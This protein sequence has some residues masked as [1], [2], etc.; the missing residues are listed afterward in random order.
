MA[1]TD[2]EALPLFQDNP[3]APQAL[4]A[5]PTHLFLIDRVPQWVSRLS[6]A[7]AASSWAVGDEMVL[8]LC[9]VDDED[10]ARFLG[11]WDR[12]LQSFAF[13]GSDAAIHRALL[14]VFW[15]MGAVN[16]ESRY[17][18][19]LDGDS[20]E[21]FR[22]LTEYPVLSRSLARWWRDER[23]RCPQFPSYDPVAHLHAALCWRSN[24]EDLYDDCFPHLLSDSL[25]RPALYGNLELIQRL[26][27]S[28]RS[29]TLI[30]SAAYG[31]QQPVL[32]WVNGQMQQLPACDR[33]ALNAAKGGHMALVRW[34]YIE[35]GCPVDDPSFIQEVA[36]HQDLEM[37]RWLQ[38]T[39]GPGMFTHH[40]LHGAAQAGSNAV[41]E[42]ADEQHP[43][44]VWPSCGT[45]CESAARH[46]HLDT[47]KWLRAKGCR[48][49]MYTS[50][51]AVE[52]GHAR[53]LRYV[54]E[55]GCSTH[56]SALMTAVAKG[57]V[58]VLDVLYDHGIQMTQDVYIHSIHHGQLGVVRWLY[59]EAEVP[60]TARVCYEAAKRGELNI[61]QY[62][63]SQGCPWNKRRCW[64]A[65]GDDETREWLRQPR[66]YIGNKR[67][68]PQ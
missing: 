60:W 26:Q 59:E 56:N 29:I 30:Y 23:A 12:L 45:L 2:L 22:P 8:A 57:W 14:G 1:A 10:P 50:Q 21:H 13:V 11:D 54:L 47:V 28:P 49:D 42:W 58:G 33:V 17:R 68:K 31:G 41:L 48:W 34:L 19:I 53:V 37:L 64:M 38:T 25:F 51:A 27:W 4:D 6:D 7:T 32:E 55:N 24:P 20:L 5:L 43:A 3:F 46:G 39:V 16:G 52:E 15:W 66:I 18:W 62:L 40:L 44:Y 67:H 36:K 61:L 9:P 35:H 63:R 65:A